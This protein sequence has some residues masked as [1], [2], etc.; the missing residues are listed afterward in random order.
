MRLENKSVPIFVIER[1]QLTGNGVFID[2]IEK[3]MGI[4]IENRGPG[5]PG[6]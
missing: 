1:N 5:R 4:R 2:E 3:R 6:K